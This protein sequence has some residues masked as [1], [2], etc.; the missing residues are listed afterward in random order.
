MNRDG[1]GKLRRG[2]RGAPSRTH[3]ARV[4]QEV[5][6]GQALSASPI[7]TVSGVAQVVALELQRQCRPQAPCTHTTAAPRTS[8][9][10]AATRRRRVTVSP[11]RAHGGVV[12]HRQRP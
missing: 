5:R 8:D 12:H 7:F 9:A 2:C 6:R 11:A 3:D 4:A 1:L 10:R